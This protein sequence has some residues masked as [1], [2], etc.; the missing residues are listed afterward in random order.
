MSSKSKLVGCD[1]CRGD[2]CAGMAVQIPT[3][4]TEEDFENTRWYLYHE[5]THIYIDRDGD[6]IAE[7][8]LPCMHRDPQT[9]QCR[10]YQQRPP[11]CRQAKLEECEKNIE[12]ALVRFRTMEDYDKWLNESKLLR[13][14][15]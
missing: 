1:Q 8:D 9:G 12:D 11:I 14:G 3:P 7:M 5:R 15:Y 13:K 4:L 10:I 6:W 2:C